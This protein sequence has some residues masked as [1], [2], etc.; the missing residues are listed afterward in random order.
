MIFEVPESN[1]KGVVTTEKMKLKNARKA[2]PIQFRIT[3]TDLVSE[4]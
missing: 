1:L 4:K 2:P 3:T